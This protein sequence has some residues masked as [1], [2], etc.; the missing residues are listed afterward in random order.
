MQDDWEMNA[1]VVMDGQWQEGGFM[2][3]GTGRERFHLSLFI[4]AL[5]GGILAA[6]IGHVLYSCMYDPSGNNVIM[7]GLI[8]AVISALVLLACSLCELHNPKITMNAE[9]N[10]SRI[11]SGLLVAAVVF[12]L[13]CLC[14][15]IY[16]RN[17]AYSPVAF[18]DYIFA[19]DDSESMLETDPLELRYSALEKLLDT[20]DK[21]KRAGLV[22]FNEN[23]YVSVEIAEMTEA[24]R[25]RL[26]NDL[27][28]TR[29]IG[30]TDIFG[31]LSTSLDM[32]QHF[33]L[34]KRSSVVVLLSDGFNSDN[35]TMA[36]FNKAVGEFL[37]KGVTI[38]TV[39]LGPNA[40]EELLENLA[41]STG[42]QYFKVEKADDLAEA[43]Q[44]VSIAVTYRCLFSPRPGIQRASVLY[45]ILRVLF[46]SLP[47]LLIGIF[48]LLLLQNRLANRQVLI[49]SVGGLLAGVAMEI[50]TFF[51]LPLAL[52]QT[53]S[54]ILYSVV[55]L[56]FYEKDSNIHQGKFEMGIPGGLGGEWGKLPVSSGTGDDP[57]RKKEKSRRIDRKDD[58]GSP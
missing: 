52:T 42:G 45:M 44:Q 32:Y 14:E 37:R 10:L 35:Y 25:T 28:D 55:L 56:R 7:V 8:L 11:L 5:L 23:A 49:S 41:Q 16:E 24:Q 1:S 46:L 34:P 40:D 20:L 15:F 58:W 54:W 18:D 17:S 22:R 29:S 4:Y 21:D 19:I 9:L 13:A 3:S 38:N 27:A 39:S 6:L 50:G 47:G 33:A 12:A 51:F 53:V 36:Q 30:G 43:F 26:N 48:I 57:Y 31:A 2:P